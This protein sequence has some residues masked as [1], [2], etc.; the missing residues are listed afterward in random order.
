M[1]ADK[2]MYIAE[3]INRQDYVPVIYSRANMDLIF[4]TS[5]MDV[6]PYLFKVSHT[7]SDLSSP[8]MGSTVRR[9]F[10]D[11]LAI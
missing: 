4:D 7:T 5:F 10:K 11:S 2:V 1:L 6:Q 3:V 9:L 8:K